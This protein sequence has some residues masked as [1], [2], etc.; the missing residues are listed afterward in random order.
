[1]TDEH[2]QPKVGER[3]KMNMQNGKIVD[4]TVEAIV[5]SNEGLKYQD[6]FG[7]EQTALADREGVEGKI[8]CGAQNE[9]LRSSSSKCLDAGMAYFGE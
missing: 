2:Q 8:A 9:R 1:V 6:D 4:A 3:I 5:E 7:F